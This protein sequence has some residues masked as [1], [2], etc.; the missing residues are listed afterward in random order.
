MD[1]KQLNSPT[2]Q[3]QSIEEE[4]GKDCREASQN[5]KLDRFYNECQGKCHNEDENTI[6]QTPGEPRTETRCY[7][8]ISCSTERRI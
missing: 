7:F 6:E 4:E 2:H 8:R 1:G 5:D 3:R